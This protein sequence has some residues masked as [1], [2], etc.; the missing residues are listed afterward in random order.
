MNEKETREQ[1]K[2]FYRENP[3]TELKAIEVADQFNFLPTLPDHERS[4]IVRGIKKL[5]LKNQDNLRIKS[6]W[7]VQKKGGE[8]VTLTS[9]QNMDNSKYEKLDSFRETFFEDLLKTSTFQ[10]KLKP[11]QGYL[12][13]VGMFDFH[14]G[15]SPGIIDEQ[16]SYYLECLNE[17]IMKVKNFDIEKIVFPVGNDLFNIDT[18][19]HTT[20]KGTPQNN[21][22][23][24]D[25]MYAKGLSTIIKAVEYLA[26]F[27]PVDIV[28]VSGN[29]DE[30]SAFSAVE[31]LKHRFYN[32]PNIQVINPVGTPRKYYKFHKVLIGYTHGDKNKPQDLPLIMAVEAKH[33]FANTD[34][35]YF[36]IGHLHH[37]IVKEFQ[38]V[39]VAVLPSL[40]T[41]DR[42]HKTQGFL[43]KPQSVINIFHPTKGKE[44][45]FIISK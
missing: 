18:V 8:I 41:A 1:I 35:H 37:N 34:H 30:F 3:K 13:E 40:A 27:A 12:I 4:S 36:H 16:C 26:H 9:W 23:D 15:K 25:E 6:K 21:N 39:Q 11:T 10:E 29:H 33:D 14:F 5:V 31:A 20:T 22:C 44:G 38:G 32:N 19:F 17:L 2:S 7:E 43:S 28:G 42:W 45:Q 24:W